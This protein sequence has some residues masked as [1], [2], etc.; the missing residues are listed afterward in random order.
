MFAV[1]ATLLAQSAAAQSVTLKT[2]TPL[3]KHSI[4]APLFNFWGEGQCDN[5]GNLYFHTGG[6][7]FRSGQIFEL[8]SDGGSGRFFQP[9]GKF[10]DP[11]VAEFS[12]FWVSKDGDVSILAIGS[13]KNYVIHFD[14]N[15]SRQLV[16]LSGKGI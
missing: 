6:S 13:G 12:N 14:G 10:A 3:T 7:G 4:E 5:N 1:V 9:T 2:V 16:P 8:A 11:D 15:G